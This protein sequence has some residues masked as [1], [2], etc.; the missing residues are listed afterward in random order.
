[1]T[2]MPRARCVD[3]RVASDAVVDSDEKIG[4][5]LGELI[6][7]PRRKSIAVT[8]TIRDAIRNALRAEHAQCAHRDRGAGR[9]VGVE[10]ADDADRVIARDRVGQQFARPVD[11][12]ERGRI[13][14]LRQFRFERVP[15]EKSSRRID[16]RK[17]R[18]HARPRARIEIAG[19]A[20]DRERSHR[21][22]DAPVRPGTG[23]Q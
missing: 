3:A 6:D 13:G 11:A 20:L 15:G 8:K 21:R 18:M 17:H 19:A 7:E 10:I 5:L 2:R 16:A 12:A 9:A 4:P 1:M 22:V 23:P 14:Q